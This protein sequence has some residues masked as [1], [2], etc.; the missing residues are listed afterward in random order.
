MIVF[1]AALSV[2]LCAISSSWATLHT[3]H[4][5]KNI[6]VRQLTQAD[7]DQVHALWLEEFDGT[8]NEITETIPQ[9]SFGAYDPDNLQDLLSFVLA[10]ESM[11]DDQSHRPC[12]NNPYHNFVYIS[13]IVTAK[14]VKR[15]GIARVLIEKVVNAAVRFPAHPFMAICTHPLDG[16]AKA[17]FLKEGFNERDTKSGTW[18]RV[19]GHVALGHTVPIP[20]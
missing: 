14:K 11:K 10:K 15:N 16:G 2:L 19:L 12:I 6:F 1:S 20:Y 13:D 9:F 18:L 17:L 3:T 5:E 4:K 7:Y 8:E